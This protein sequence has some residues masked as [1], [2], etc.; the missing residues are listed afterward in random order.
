MMS[1]GEL[2]RLADFIGAPDS[3]A[4]VVTPMRFAHVLCRGEDGTRQHLKM[5]WGLVPPWEKDPASG[6]RFL[7]ARG[8]SLDEKRTFKE[9][10]LHRRGLLIVK[11]FNEGEEVSPSKTRQY[12]VTPRDGMPLAIAVIWERWNEEHAGALLTFAMVTVAANAL[13]SKITDRMP[14]VIHPD[15]WSKWLGEEAASDEDLKAMLVPS[16][17]DWDMAP[18]VKAPPA[19]PRRPDPQPGLL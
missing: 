19:R 3:A 6:T 18:E 17:G 7:H 5:R 11:T 8:E 9:A 14:A 1:W 10:F 16:D 4:E 2:V 15:A 13:I 12:I